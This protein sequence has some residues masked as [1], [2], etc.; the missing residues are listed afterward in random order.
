MKKMAMTMSVFLVVGL[1]VALLLPRLPI[2]HATT[3]NVAQQVDPKPPCPSGI[4]AGSAFDGTNLWFSC[5]AHSTDLY[6]V[7]TDGVITASYRIDGGL[8]ALVYDSERNGIWASW[9]GGTAGNGAVWFI[10]LD[11]AKNVVGAR[12]VAKVSEGI[13]C[14]LNNGLAY[15]G[16]TGSLYFSNACSRTIYRYA[17]VPGSPPALGAHLHDIF[18]A[19]HQYGL[20]LSDRR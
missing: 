15:N 7:G 5:S 9:G 2:A 4:G 3:G 19:G 13:S 14:D 12:L 8:G 11:A 1:A 10:S 16:L 20:Q 6:R 18:P 17:V